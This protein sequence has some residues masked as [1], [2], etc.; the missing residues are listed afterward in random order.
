MRTSERR[1]R[2]HRGDERN[3]VSD[4]I[5]KCECSGFKLHFGFD[6]DDQDL[7]EL[8]YT[9]CPYCKMPFCTVIKPPGD[10]PPLTQPED[11]RAIKVIEQLTESNR[12]L[13]Q[14]NTE[15]KSLLKCGN[16][17][18]G[19]SDQYAYSEDGGKKIICLLCRS[20]EV[21]QLRELLNKMIT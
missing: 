4:F 19:H 11:P 3:K 8:H 1:P 21:T 2:P 5:Y 14:E 6:I 18:C 10:Y 13:K 16:S 7:R 15:L 9:A 12:Q 17:P 20:N